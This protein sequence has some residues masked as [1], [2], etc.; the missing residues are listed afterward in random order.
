M[1]LTFDDPAPD[2]VPDAFVIRPEGDHAQLSYIAFGSE[3]AMLKRVSCQTTL[4]G[5]DATRTYVQT[6]QRPTNSEMTAIF[7]ADQAARS[8]TRAINWKVVD[9]EDEKR[10]VRTQVLLDAGKLQSADDF[11]H[12]A[13]IFQHGHKGSDYLKAHALAVI[14]AA[15]GKPAATWIAAA[16][17]DR[18]LQAIGQPQIYGTQFSNR[19]DGWTQEPYQQS[20]LPDA[21]RKASRVPTL[22][23]QEQQRLEYEKQA[24]SAGGEV[25]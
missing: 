10:R 13:F 1:E 2:S 22:S 14:A 20:I 23:E 18:Y 25:P 12:A 24:A 16:T 19:N 9:T 8:T 5:W 17:L 21:L 11:Y 4:G 6:L 15:R 3:P 7:D